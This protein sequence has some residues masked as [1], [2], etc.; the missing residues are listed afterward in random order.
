MNLPV[1]RSAARLVGGRTWAR[2]VVWVSLAAMAGSLPLVSVTAP[3][4][5]AAAA[6]TAVDTSFGGGFVATNL[7]DLDDEGFAVAVQPDG[8]TVVAGRTNFDPFAWQ[9]GDVLVARYTPAGQLDPSF[10]SGGAF[11]LGAPNTMDQAFAVTLQD[12]GKILVAAQ[13]TY[14]PA[15]I[16]LTPA[17]ALD[18]EFQGGLVVIQEAGASANAVAVRPDGKVSFAGDDVV[19]GRLNPDGSRDATF[20]TNG[21]VA[22]PPTGMTRRAAFVLAA[23]GALLVGGVQADPNFGGGPTEVAVLARYLASGQRDTRFGAGGVVTT[24]L[25]TPYIDRGAQ[26]AG[27]AVQP[28]GKIVAV[29]RAFMFGGP[30]VPPGPPQGEPPTPPVQH[31]SLGAVLVLRYLPDG[32]PDTT[33]A[34]VGHT[35]TRVPGQT[36][37][38]SETPPAVTQPDAQSEASSVA[39]DP[40]GRILVGGWSRQPFDEPLLLR[41]TSAG[42]LDTTFG[43]S[44]VLSVERNGLRGR[45]LA[46]A[47][48]SDDRLVVTGDSRGGYWYE[49]PNYSGV[50]AGRVV[51]GSSTGAVWAWGWNAVGQL[52]DGTTVDRHAPIPI[53]GLTGVVGVSAGLYHTLALRGDGTVWAWGW[54]GLGQLGDGSTVDRRSPVRVPGLSGVVAVAAGGLHSLALRGDGTVWA[55]GWNGFGQLGDG[56]TE[57]RP[58]PVRV[59]RLG[60]VFQISAGLYHNLAVREDGSG[61]GWGMNALGQL[62]DGTTVDRHVPAALPP[63]EGF[64]Y[65]EAYVSVS[66]GWLHSMSVGA[67]GTPKVWGWNGLGQAAGNPGGTFTRPGNYI[68]A[69]L[70]LSGGGYHSVAVQRDGSVHHYGWMVDGQFGRA[71]GG[72]VLPRLNSVASPSAGGLHSLVVTRDRRVRSWGWNY[73]GQLGTRNTVSSTTPVLVVSLTNAAA[74]SAG[75]FH[76]VAVQA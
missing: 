42:V 69:G 25:D 37:P 52:G 20:G 54:N 55:W 21:V 58:R 11:V 53:S 4:G 26:I 36:G 40:S 17:G 60:G 38:G 75:A 9:G 16:R 28:D 66:A 71:P 1:K 68:G 43:R 18:A 29:G 50:L 45:I 41:Y 49:P 65:N 44:G 27:L 57:L 8:A 39:L 2:T 74:A 22:A 59:A 35:I 24:N 34:G 73:F 32:R 10:G 46:I 30:A 5:A 7:S 14:R 76:S 19:V 72:F 51:P 6:A 33:F 13:Y 48:G 64:Q 47:L 67:S 12:D 70:T 56:T 31:L 62:G 15:I 61:W 23:D 3:V 63:N